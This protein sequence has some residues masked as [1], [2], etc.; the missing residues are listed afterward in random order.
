MPPN[1]GSAYRALAGELREAIAA[2]EYDAATPLPTEMAIAASRKVSRQTVRRAFQEL[3]AEGLVYR[4]PGRGTFATPP[5]SRYGRTVTS[6]EDL[7]ALP[8]DTEMEV[9]EALCGDYDVDAAAALQ[10]T[11]RQLYSV[12]FRRRHAGQVFCVTSAY[13]PAA[14]GLEL[15]DHPGLSAPGT[16]VHDTVIGILAR[17][18]YEVVAA[19]QAVTAV[20]ANAWHA[21]QLGCAIGAPLLHIERTYVDS[22]GIPV[23]HAVSDYLP[24][25]YTLRQGLDRTRLV[26]PRQDEHR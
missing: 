4:V 2:G 11:V 1:P 10:L 21:D 23:E 17:R 12:R 19:D 6:I 16:I 13:L 9:A 22:A 25:M 15:E 18:G 3:V 5:D 7:L 20:S 24:E 14:I 8:L 26:P